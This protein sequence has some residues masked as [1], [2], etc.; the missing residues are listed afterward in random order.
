MEQLMM[1]RDDKEVGLIQFPAGYSM[2]SWQKG[3]ETGWCKCCIDGR[4]GVEEISERAFEEK[5]LN[6]KTVNPNNIFFLISPAGEI[7]GTVT[8]QYT[9]DETTGCIHM[10]GIKKNHRGKGLAVS[11]NLY[12]VQKMIDDGKK[13][14]ILTT[15]DWRIP[16]IKTYL[17]AGFTPVI[18]PDDTDME[19]RWTAVMTQV[20]TIKPDIAEVDSPDEK[21]RICLA[22]LRALPEWF[23]I[24]SAIQ[25]YTSSVR[26]LPFFV[27]RKDGRDVGF[28][29]LKQNT[30][31]AMEIHVMGV[32]KEYHRRGI[33][34]ALLSR[35]EQYGRANGVEFLTVKTLNESVSC[36]FY[37]QTRQ[38]YRHA[39]FKPLEVFP[40]FWNTENPCLFLVKQI[41]R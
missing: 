6:D 7:A 25:G 15:D 19:N 20:K 5:M 29:T 4:L 24:E 31:C 3:D 33:G 13:R 40:L 17:R 39:G 16:A 28:L 34:A 11:L 37:E 30:A 36:D 23:S 18:R 14:I 10:V 26:P 21:S 12:A 38:F 8:Y 32:L 1:S 9:N 35:A 41:A 27:A 2:R 22:V